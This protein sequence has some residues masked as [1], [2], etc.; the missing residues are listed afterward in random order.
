MIHL[1][2]NPSTFRF[3]QLHTSSYRLFPQSSRI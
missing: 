2:I 1:S 3:T